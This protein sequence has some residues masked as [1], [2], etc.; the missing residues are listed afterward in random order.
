MIPKKYKQLRAIA[1]AF[2]FPMK[3]IFWGLYT[4]QYSSI[5]IQ[6]FIFLYNMETFLTN[7]MEAIYYE[8][9]VL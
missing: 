9:N 8:S 1:S 2:E 3:Q 4:E 6:R 7:E 5:T